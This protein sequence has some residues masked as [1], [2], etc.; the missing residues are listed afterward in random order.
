[1]TAWTPQQYQ[2]LRDNPTLSNE[3]VAALVSRHGP[4]KSAEAVDSRRR[5]LGLPRISTRN[6]RRSA[7]AIRAAEKAK[8]WPE[9]P[10]SHEERDRRFVAMALREALR[11]GI[12]KVAA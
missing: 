4:E 1:M 5:A 11:I 6:P 8:G 10:G 9:L 7:G 2:V 12:L 3:D